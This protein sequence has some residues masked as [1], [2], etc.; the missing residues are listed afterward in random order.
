MTYGDLVSRVKFDMEHDSPFS[1]T[2]H[3]CNR[4]CRNKAIRVS[5]Y[6]IL[7]LAR[8]LCISTTQFI[9]N[10]TEAGGTVLRLKENGDCGFLGERGCSV[11]PDRPLACRIYPLARW[12]SP[13]GVESFGHLTPHP[14]TEGVYGTLGT[15]QDY[16]DQQQLGPFFET[17]ERYGKLYQKMVEILEKLDP[18]ELD[19]RS[20]RRAGVDEL[21]PGTFASMWVDI[22]ASIADANGV[23]GDGQITI[24]E[25]I[26]S[27]VNRIKAWLI[28]LTE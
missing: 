15:V 17:S 26:D 3:A 12:V 9:E 20:D 13:D 22:D 8:Y 14:K 25:A 1:Y 21:P 19:R 16:L 23:S 18:E 5:P 10:H 27:H 2:C 11:H 24:N 28:S 4:C 6:E 7:R